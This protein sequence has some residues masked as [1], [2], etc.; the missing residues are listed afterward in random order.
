MS[1][2]LLTTLFMVQ[3]RMILACMATRAHCCLMFGW[4]LT[5]TP[6]SFFPLCSFSAQSLLHFMWLL[7]A[8]CRNWHLV[9]LQL[10]Q[11]HSAHRSSSSGGMKDFVTEEYIFLESIK[12]KLE[13]LTRKLYGIV[14]QL[15]FTYCKS[16]P[17]RHD[18]LLLQD[19]FG[20]EIRKLLGGCRLFS[21]HLLPSSILIYLI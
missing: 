8:K 21:R 11:L 16:Y 2:I 18:T 5:N 20:K 17:M 19:S 7:W 14:S 12:F 1:L 13:V 15:L 3:V 6:R 4:L 10:I 9:L